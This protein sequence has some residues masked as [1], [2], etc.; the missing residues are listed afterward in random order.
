MKLSVICLLCLL[1]ERL[2]QVLDAVRGECRLT[3]DTHD[4]KDGSTNL[5]VVLDDGN[6][7]VCDDGNVNLYAD[8]V[9][10]LSPESFDLE[11]LFDPFEEQLH[12]PPVFIKKSDVLGCK[13]EIV[14]VVNKTPLEFRDIVDNP[15]DDSGIFL[16][17]LLFVNRILWSLR[18]LSV[19]SSM[20]SPSTISYGGLPFSLMIKNAPS[21]LMR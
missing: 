14:R 10:G 7:A 11:M 13:I 19:P 1:S 16:L 15:S 4:F 12:L 5:E 2:E 21:T 3:K 6:E 20:L 8:C 18:T 17:I 9:L